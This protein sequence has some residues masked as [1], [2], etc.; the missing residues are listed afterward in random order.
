M[1]TD[2]IASA[3]RKTL[4]ESQWTVETTMQSNENNIVKVLAGTST[5]YVNDVEML[6]GEARYSG[7]VVFDLLFVDE[8]GANHILSDRVSFDGKIQNDQINPLMKPIFNVEIVDT[9]VENV[10]DD[11]VKMTATV[12]LKLDAVQADE[13]DVLKCDVSN[14]EFNKEP[15]VLSKI[16]STGNASFEVDEE[17]DTKNNVKRVL[18]SRAHLNVKNVSAGTGYFTVE[19][20]MFLNS[21]LEVEEDDA[22]VLKNFSETIPF[23]EEIE[24]DKIE[25]DDEVFAMTTIRPQDLMVE[26]V[27]QD[28]SEEAVN[29]RNSVLKVDAK[30]LVK[31]IVQRQYETEIATDAF[32]TTNKTNVVSGTFKTANL[33]KLEKLNLTIDGQTLIDE[34]EPRI[35]KICAV[36]N[37]H[38]LVANSVVSDGELT[39]EGVAYATVIYLTDDDV[40]ELNSVD[41]E[42]PFSNKFDVPTD[43]EGELY[44]VADIKDVDAKAKKGKEINISLDVCFLVYAYSSENRVALKGIELADV[45]S[46]SEYAL[47]MYV[48]PK[49]STLWNVS[50]QMLVCGDEIMEQNPNLVFPLES[51]QTIV[52]FRKK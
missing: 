30:V 29:N 20:D 36:T 13:V 50:K 15:A 19:G 9:K 42:I 16:V 33:T 8:E 7:E 25:R 48:A 14:I 11:M 24:D 26:I 18:L 46:P 27:S 39:L 52:H 51:S 17:Y 49:G 43:F 21:V 41:L 10:G 22:T 31:Y 4:G 38:I 35:S 34:D 44:V 1:E 45:L 47:E 5:A 6:S 37:E 40:P 23:K 32:S 3:Y 2:K 28:V 12:A